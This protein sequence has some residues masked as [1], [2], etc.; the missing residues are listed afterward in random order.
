MSL[1]YKSSSIIG[2]PLDSNVIEQFK[3]RRETVNKKT[4]RSTEDVL[5]LNS[6]TGW[7]KMTSSVDV[8][9][10]E[11]LD[12]N[13]EYSN[14]PARNSV[15][16]GGTLAFNRQLGGIFNEVDTAYKKSQL[17]GY[18]PMAGITGFQV[19]AK[20]NFGTLRV[21]T[22]NFKVNSVEELDELEQLF[23]RP[24][25]SVLLEWG[26]SVYYDNSGKLESN[27]N[28]FGNQF[29][30]KMKS[31]DI[32][33]EIKKLKISSS[34]NYDGMYGIIKNFIWAYNL[35]GGYDCRVD[36]V[37]KGE[38]IESLEMVISPSTVTKFKETDLYFKELQN[39]TA[40]H[41]FLN[42]IKNA[43]T[44]AYHSTQEVESS[45]LL[46]TSIDAALKEFVPEIFD[47]FKKNLTESGRGFHVLRARVSG[48]I[49]EELGQW[50]RFITLSSL[51]ELVNLLFTIKTH[52]GGLIKFFIGDKGNKVTTPFLTFENH[53]ALDPSIAV[54]PKSGKNRTEGI[55]RYYKICEQAEIPYTEDDLL[56]IYINIDF[57]LKTADSITESKEPTSKALYDFLNAILRGVNSTLGDINDFDLHFEEE[58]N[59]FYV[60][61]RKITP[62][63][64]DIEESYLDLI[65]LNSTME[66]I[67]FA[68]KLSSNV[69]SMMAIAAQAGNTNV[70]N[71]MLAM[72]TWQGGLV[73]R[74]NKDK[75]VSLDE[76]GTTNKLGSDIDFEDQ[77][78]L[79]GFISKLDTT[80]P[81]YIKYNK[82]DIQGLYPTFRLL[83]VR[84][85]EFETI[86]KKLNPAG[87]IPF[88]LSF[89][90]KGIGGMKIGQAFKVDDKIIPRRYR[91]NVAFLVTGVSH[92]IQ[93]NR[94]VTDIKTQM[95]I[96]GKPKGIEIKKQPQ[97]PQISTVQQSTPTPNPSPRKPIQDLS[98]SQKGINLIKKAEGFEPRAYV[99][100]GSGNQPI[101]IGYGTTRI[102]G[103]PIS[104]GTTI[105][106]AQAEAYFKKDLVSYENDV[107]RYVRV[108]VTQEE[109]DALVS[110]TY[111]L[112]AGNLQDSTLRKKINQK[113]YLGAADEFLAWNKAG[114]KV[115]PGLVK[116]R[117][118]EKQLFLTNNPG[119][120][121]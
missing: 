84:Y 24:G 112:G 20:N 86:D 107:K 43:E 3:V 29:F 71:D 118:Q 63:N 27:I 87:L 57:I 40:L 98:I 100:P 116:R 101:T 89:T 1:G 91:G 70:G 90:T 47:K 38:L 54:L 74:H 111:N 16:L 80:N 113:D 11:D 93:A 104:L 52:D 33:K 9:V 94:W 6:N 120:L 78:R 10:G 83:M 14:A 99:D 25:F 36:I 48:D 42:I 30:G 17:L 51:L 59:T 58:N 26:H 37:S 108:D 15:L 69:T 2:G 8:E 79:L 35:D 31:D 49:K 53:F 39:K 4:G 22:V 76:V 21:A 103:K 115:L 109:F 72:Q 56:N 95:I 119:N 92:S 82:E 19:D 121:T 97:A 50:T 45:N 66:N 75:R 5:A 117:S 67:S 110:F 13:T 18:R 28:T 62:S 85:L 46:S 105:T 88:E 41:S 60:V 114:G 77:K 23:L 61:D 73:D 44:E 55:S 68:S 12:G 65:G 32:S 96:T 7:V 81:Y 106:E 64:T 34:G 102:N